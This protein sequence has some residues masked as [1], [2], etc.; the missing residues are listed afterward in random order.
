[1]SVQHLLIFHNTIH[2]IVPLKGQ[3]ME[4]CTDTFFMVIFYIARGSCLFRCL[5][6]IQKLP[7][8]STIKR[9]ISVNDNGEGTGCIGGIIILEY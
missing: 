7:R 5:E 8:Y 2:L 6:L 1:M 4:I 3:C 9:L